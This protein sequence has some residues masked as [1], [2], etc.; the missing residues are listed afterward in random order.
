MEKINIYIHTSIRSV[1]QQA[2]GF[3][4]WVLE[5]MTSKGEPAT[6][7]NKKEITATWKEAELTA[8]IQA[9]VR[10]KKPCELTIFTENINIISAFNNGWMDKWSA[11]DWKNAK[12]EQIENADKW[13]ELYKVI[14]MHTISEALDKEN[15]YTSWMYSECGEEIKESEKQYLRARTTLEHIIESLE[16]LDI[17]TVEKNT[18]LKKLI[19]DST[20]IL[21]EKFDFLR[22]GKNTGLVRIENTESKEKTLYTENEKTADSEI[23]VH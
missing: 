3:I 10:V 7:T 11:N 12:G 14:S 1:R 20:E 5:F 13:Q 9:L 18:D 16:S 23:I 17:P 4:I 6:I 2:M 22:A 15:E 21:F 8:L 19:T